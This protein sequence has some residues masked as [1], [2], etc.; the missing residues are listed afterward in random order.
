MMRRFAWCGTNQSM[1]PAVTPASAKQRLDDVG[2]HAD[3][4]PEH[5][6]A[7]HPQMADGLGRRGAAVDVELGCNGRPSERNCEAMTPGEP[8]A[9]SLSWASSTIAPAPSPNS[10]QVARSCQSRMREKV[11]AP[12]TSARLCEAEVRN[13]SAVVTAKTKPEQ[14]ACRS[15]ATP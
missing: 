11:S 7:L 12:I 4:V 13:L 15:N 6:L 10:T 8:I 1:S 14:T 2:H 9:P 3:G 5:F